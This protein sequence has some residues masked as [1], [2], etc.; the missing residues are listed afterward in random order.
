METQLNGVDLPLNL[1]KM[2]KEKRILNGS[3]QQKLEMCQKNI[4]YMNKTKHIKHRLNQEKVFF[5]K[6][7]VDNPLNSILTVELNTTE[8]CNRTCVFCPR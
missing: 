4:G 7:S 5:S 2:L 3:S 8:L 1:R 6:V